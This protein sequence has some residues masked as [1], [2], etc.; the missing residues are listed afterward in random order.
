MSVRSKSRI[1]SEE[2]EYVSWKSGISRVHPDR[3][4]KLPLP[5]INI[6]ESGPI[7]STPSQSKSTAVGLGSEKIVVRSMVV[8]YGML[9]GAGCVCRKA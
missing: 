2:G 8:R 6:E 4:L 5:A 7:L 3:L 9:M 1:T